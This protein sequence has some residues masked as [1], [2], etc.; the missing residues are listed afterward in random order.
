[1]YKKKSS[2]RV[3]YIFTILAW[4]IIVSAVI[5]FFDQMQ[6]IENWSPIVRARIDMVHI[7][8]LYLSSGALVASIISWLTHE[9]QHSSIIE[10]VVIRRF[11]PLIR[12]VVTAGIWIIVLLEML[13]KLDVDTKS[14]LTGAG[15]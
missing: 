15:I 8:L 14:I 11:L 12:F 7:I 5:V 2:S 13:E 6:S 1:M 3:S 4:I 9:V 10:N